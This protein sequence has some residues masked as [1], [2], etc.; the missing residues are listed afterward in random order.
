[1]YSA[2]GAAASA[3][4][5]FNDNGSYT[6]YGRIFDQD[7][8]FTD[9]STTVTVNDVPP[10][11]GVSGPATGARGQPRTF[12]FTATDPSPIDQ[13]APFSYAIDWADGSS[14]QTVTG[15]GAS[16]QVTHVFTDSGSFTVQARA[17][18]K[19]GGQ[20]PT[21]GSSTITIVAADLQGG[22]LVVGGTLQGDTIVLKPTDRSGDIGVTINGASVG[23]FKPTSQ[24][25][26]Y[27]QAGDDTVLLQ[28]AKIQG[29]T[30]TISI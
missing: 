23:V 3:S 5:T 14:L 29:K 24:I 25:I 20:S 12:T 16:I 21:A 13:A 2:A 6:V 8:G 22:T 30:V 26:V 18:D 1:S 17:T 27:A 10:I 9:Y 11:T 15:A 4:F 19:D 7:N 28:S